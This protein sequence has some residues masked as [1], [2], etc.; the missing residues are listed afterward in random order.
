MMARSL[1]RKDSL[2]PFPMQRPISEFLS[3]PASPGRVPDRVERSRRQSRAD[4]IKLG[5]NHEERLSLLKLEVEKHGPKD[6]LENFTNEFVNGLL[7][8]GIKKKNASQAKR[9]FQDLRQCTL[10]YD[11]LH[12]LESNMNEN[13]FKKF[14]FSGFV[15]FSDSV[16]GE[17]VIWIDVGSLMR[18]SWNYMVGTPKSNALVRWLL[19]TLQSLLVQSGPDSFYTACLDFVC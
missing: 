8:N 10:T 4:I 7:S 15:I 5:S 13:A 12:E 16:R 14:M 6:L 19:F 1:E 3:R 17:R 11:L 18:G 2:D 9:V